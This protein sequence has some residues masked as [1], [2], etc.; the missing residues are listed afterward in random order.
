MP[1]STA[2]N[3]VLREQEQYL[4]SRSEAAEQPEEATETLD[5]SGARD[6]TEE[7]KDATR[8]VCLLLHEAHQGRA[9]LALG[10]ASWEAYVQA[11]FSLSRSRS[12]ELLDQSRVIRTLMAAAGTSGTPEISA[13]CATQVKPYLPEMIDEVRVRTAGTSEDEAL[14]I[15]LKVV[16]ERRQLIDRER[17]DRPGAAATRGEDDSSAGRVQL[18][19]LRQVIGQLARMPPVDAVIASLEGGDAGDLESMDRALDWLE[20]F[21]AAWKRRQP[22]MLTALAER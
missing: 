3:L 21:A 9:W 15:V 1:V 11:E 5:E 22:G 7:I 13:Y 12:Y 4:I 18:L 8:Q 16:R 10:Y 6:L 19:Q 2:I 17:S 20:E 14:A